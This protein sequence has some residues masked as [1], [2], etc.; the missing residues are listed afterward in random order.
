MSRAPQSSPS[1]PE[2]ELHRR[3]LRPTVRRL[4]DLAERLTEEIRPLLEKIAERFFIPGYLMFQIRREAGSTEWHVK[5]FVR[6]VGMPPWHL[7]L[8]CRIEVA[9][10]LLRETSLTVAAIAPLVGYADENGLRKLFRNWCDLTPAQAR[11]YL[12]KVDRQRRGAGDEALSWSL[13]VRFHRG[14]VDSAEMDAV[15]S[16]LRSRFSPK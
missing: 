5:L 8:L 1:G 12:R 4:R 3:A 15:Q 7:V 16:Y 9:L 10:W 14:E 13:R 6:Q 11:R 2:G